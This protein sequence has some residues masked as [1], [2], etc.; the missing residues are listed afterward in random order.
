[1]KRIIVGVA[2]LWLA[3]VS[4]PGQT[5]DKMAEAAA[6]AAALKQYQWKSRTEIQ[7]DGE[8]KNVQVVLMHYD[9]NGQLQK[10]PV[11]GTP[12][13]ELPKF[14]LR[15]RIA[16]KKLKEFRERVQDLGALAKSYSE[17]TPEQMQRFMATASFTPQSMQHQKLVRIEGQN[18]LQPGDSMTMWINAISRK[19]RRIE[20]Q[21][22]LDGK[23]VRIVLSFLD[24]PNGGPTY[25]S[26]S[27]VNYNGG[28]V[29]I[30]MENFDYARVQV[31]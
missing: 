25:M 5:N 4:M 23:P 22:I 20:I 17:L 26:E 18:V 27:H 6:N 13:P 10:T 14:G 21:T 3:A 9:S 15:K 31:G 8:T 28:D 1:M 30:I 24:I 12:E 11:S 2:L 29:V 7:K 16:Q 19:Q